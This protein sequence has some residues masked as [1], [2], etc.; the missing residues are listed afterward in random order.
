[1]LY[2]YRPD[3][4]YEYLKTIIDDKDASN[5]DVNH[6]EADDNFLYGI[7]NT[8]VLDFIAVS[9]NKNDRNQY[10]KHKNKYDELLDASTKNVSQFEQLS[11]IPKEFIID[12][13]HNC[14]TFEK[15]LQT[16]VDKI[17]EYLS[18][19]RLDIRSTKKALIDTLWDE[20]HGFEVDVPYTNGDFYV[21]ITNASPAYGGYTAVLKYPYF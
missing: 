6:L 21:Y 1:M 8:Y 18:D 4:I 11:I 15:P 7:G 13:S 10:I 2:L 17:M 16:I 5:T 14:W 20:L 19:R 3:D 12:L 9:T